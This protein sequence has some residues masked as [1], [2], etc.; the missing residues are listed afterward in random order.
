MGHT[1]VMPIET[2]YKCL[3]TRF[4]EMTNVACC[5]PGFLSGNEGLSVDGSESV[6][7]DFSSYGL[8]WVYDDS[9]GS[10]V[11]LFK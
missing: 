11:E 6:N 8:D 4:G 3:D 1:V 9:D 10:R 7:D 5:L 2:M